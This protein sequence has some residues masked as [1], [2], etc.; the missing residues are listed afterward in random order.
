MAAGV[1][2]NQG[3]TGLSLSQIS[4][5]PGRCARLLRFPDAPCCQ[6]ALVKIV[7]K[8]LGSSRSP[9]RGLGDHFADPV[10]V[11]RIPGVV[12]SPFEALKRDRF[13]GCIF[14]NW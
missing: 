2:R 4:G 3:T 10:L 5:K 11:R 9:V 7:S 1:L 13:D 14:T 12:A 6:G 8:E